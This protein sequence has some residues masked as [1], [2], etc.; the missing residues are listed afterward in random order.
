MQVDTVLD[1]PRALHLNLQAAAGDCATLETSKATSTVT[2]TPTKPYLLTVLLPLSQAFE[3]TS[4]W[5]PLLFKPLQEIR[6]SFFLIMFLVFFYGVFLITVVAI[7]IL[8]M[9]Y[10]LSNNGVGFTGTSCAR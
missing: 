9:L 3:H 7:Q 1:E 2:S 8:R 10:P 5:G 6:C 4:L